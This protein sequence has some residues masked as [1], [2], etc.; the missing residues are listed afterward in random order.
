MVMREMKARNVSDEE[1]MDFVLHSPEML[2]LFMS[3][4]E[5]EDKKN[6]VLSYYKASSHPNKE[7]VSVLEDALFLSSS[8]KETIPLFDMLKEEADKFIKMINL[9]NML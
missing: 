6:K 5:T 7:L 1:G 9:E 8:R 3:S 4:D 2:L